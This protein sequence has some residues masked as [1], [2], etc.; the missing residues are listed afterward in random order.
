MVIPIATRRSRKAILRRVT[1]SQLLATFAVRSVV[2][3]VSYGRGDEWGGG[4]WETPGSRLLG[5]V[6]ETLVK[7][8][9]PPLVAT[10]SKCS[11]PTK[12]LMRSAPVWYA[13]K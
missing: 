1:L 7:R 13:T 10:I 6:S 11:L 9:F 5:G 8:N 2:N 3:I 12:D 4:G